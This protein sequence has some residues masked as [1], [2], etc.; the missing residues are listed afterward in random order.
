MGRRRIVGRLDRLS[1]IRTKLDVQQLARRIADR[2]GIPVEELL[3]EAVR[4]AEVS[5]RRG[6]TTV[7][8][9]IAYQAEELGIPVDELEAEITQIR[10]RAA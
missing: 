6:I 7:A 8:G 4:I 9:M 3:A 10:E 5:Q 1:T 2:E